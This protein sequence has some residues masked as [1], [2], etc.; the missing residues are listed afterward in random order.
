MRYLQLY[1]CGTAS[2]GSVN[3]NLSTVT[4]IVIW[5][6]LQ[7]QTVMMLLQDYTVTSRTLIIRTV[8]TDGT[9]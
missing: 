7:I 1:S 2:D 4:S 9:A 5:S 3:F 6:T 8:M